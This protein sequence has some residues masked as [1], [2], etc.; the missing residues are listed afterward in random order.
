MAY[1]ISAGVPA[2]SGTFIPQLWAGKWLEKFYASSV[3]TA[4]ANTDYEGMIAQQGDT[5]N[6]RTVPD[7]QIR[8]YVAGQNL[9]GPTPPSKWRAGSSSGQK[10][11]A[12]RRF[13]PGF[14]AAPGRRWSRG[15][16]A[17]GAARLAAGRSRLVWQPSWSGGA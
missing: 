8:D 14:Y 12:F 10:G 15:R 6:I 13:E 1:P 2:Q 4:I 3:L 17:A 9:T 5:V 16:A 11:R 7:I